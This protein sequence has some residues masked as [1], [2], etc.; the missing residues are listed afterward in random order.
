MALKSFIKSYSAELLHWVYPLFCPCCERSVAGNSQGICH[1]CLQRL[2]FTPYHQEGNNPILERLYG[3]IPLVHGM[4]MLRYEKSGMAQQ[5]I[6]ALKYEKRP[7]IGEALGSVYGRKIIKEGYPSNYDA[8]IPVPLHEKKRFK[9]GYNQSE[10]F[11]NGIAE[12]LQI[13]VFNKILLRNRNASTQTALSRE[14]RWNNVAMDYELRNEAILSNQHIL[15]VDDV[16]TTGA[17]LEACGRVLL[18]I[19]KLKLSVATIAFA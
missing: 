15:L 16:L 7:E 5:L 13:P 10:E 17:T 14:A 2:P 19:P 11:A 4:S 12:K 3:R 9:R 6:H 18:S 8:I 1:T